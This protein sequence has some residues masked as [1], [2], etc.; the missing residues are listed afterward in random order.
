MVK[1]IFLKIE[2]KK[3]QIR[4]HKDFD[5]I[6]TMYQCVRSPEAKKLIMYI[7][8]SSRNDWELAHQAITG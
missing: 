3:L 1:K 6:V 7:N 4:L 2:K 5:P 8:G